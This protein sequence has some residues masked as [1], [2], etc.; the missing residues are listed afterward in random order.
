M[1]RQT[2]TEAALAKMRPVGVP[3]IYD[4]WKNPGRCAWIISAARC[5]FVLV[6]AV[7]VVTQYLRC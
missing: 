6:Y 4:A 2:A 3:M 7:E 1:R 5:F